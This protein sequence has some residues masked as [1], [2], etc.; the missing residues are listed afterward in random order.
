MERIQKKVTIQINGEFMP[1]IT[2][3]E[4]FTT[5][6][7]IGESEIPQVI[8]RIEVPEKGKIIVDDGIMVGE[9]A[10]V[11]EVR[12]GFRKSV[13]KTTKQGIVHATKKYVEIIDGIEKRDVIAP[14][15]G[16]LLLAN[17]DSYSAE[18]SFIKIPL[19]IS[20]GSMVAAQSVLLTDLKSTKNLGTD[21]FEKIVIVPG[22]LSKKLTKELIEQ[23]VAGIVAAS[24][25]WDDY[26]QIFRSFK[27][28]IGI[29]QGF[30]HLQLWDWMYQLLGFE[31][32]FIRTHAAQISP[33][34][35]VDFRNS[36]LYISY[37][38]IMLESLQKSVYIFKDLYWGKKIKKIQTEGY[39]LIATLD[40]GE[41]TSV[42]EEELQKII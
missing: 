5:G 18:V 40:S 16:R 12:S 10:V 6:E 23:K 41:Q 24:V 38:D 17:S 32:Q 2:I 26:E 21:L 9:G 31:Q 1:K 37:N 35:E 39:H 13:I 27:A 42:V 11:I 15:N 4:L 20:A 28:N 14:C 22:P 3:G 7:K 19:L 36:C 30:G 29:L 25:N 34:I 33:Y 8:E